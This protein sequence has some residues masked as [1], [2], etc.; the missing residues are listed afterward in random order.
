LISEKL[1]Q[2][3]PKEFRAECD[4]WELY[5]KSKYNCNA[6]RKYIYLVT[7]DFTKNKIWVCAYLSNLYNTY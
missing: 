3:D 1:A 7:E 5:K 4:G 2:F 6:L